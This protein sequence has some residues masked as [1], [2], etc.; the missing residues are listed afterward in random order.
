MTQSMC[1]KAARTPLLAAAIALAF[2]SPFAAAASSKKHFEQVNYDQFIV[3]FKD[4]TVEHANKSQ[5]QQRLDAVGRAQGLHIAQL[6]RMA[7]GADVIHTDHMLTP[8]Q[9]KRLIGSLRADPRVEYAE[10]DRMLYPAFTPD[11]TTYAQQWHYYEAI[12]GINAPTAWDTTSGTGQVIAVLDTGITVHTDL[13]ANIIAGYD[14]ISST[15]TANDGDGRDADAS[16]PG[17][18]V[19]LTQ[20]GTNAADNSSWHGTHVA[21]TIAAVTNNAFGVAG[22][23]YGAKV[24]PVRV[25][26]T[27]GGSTSDISDA[28]AWASGETVAGIP[29]VTTPAD[30]I[31]MS[32]G[33]SGSCAGA[34]QNAV[35]KAVANGTVV[36]VAAGNSNADASGFSPANCNN[37]VTV[38]AVGRTGGRASYSNYGTKIDIAAPGGDDGQ[39]IRS[40][41]NAGTTVPTTETYAGYQGTSMAAPHVAGVA[42]LVGAVNTSLTPAQME[43]LLKVTART[44]PVPCSLGCGSGLLDAGAAVL[45]AGT[46]VLNITDPLDVDEGNSGTKTYT[47]TVNLS[48]A[49]GTAVTFDIATSNGTATAGSDYVAK[50]SLAQ[51]IAA[52][53]TSK[54][55]VVTFN[56]DTTYEDNEVF[57]V[58]ITNVSGPV[59][60]IDDQGV[61]EIGNDDALVL[62]PNVA[63]TGLADGDTGHNKNFTMA[64]PANAT[65]LQFQIS[66][67]T[68]DADLYVRFG[69]APTEATFDCAPY[70][71]GNNETCSQATQAG[72]WYVMVDAYAPYT[73]VTL[74]GSYTIPADTNISVGDVSINEGNGGTKLVT[75][76]VTLSNTS[77]GVVGFDIATADGTATAGS[78]YVA[79]TSTAQTIA[80]GQLS[81][82]FTVTVNGDSAVETNETILANLTNVTG[83]NV[84]DAQGVATITND[85]GPTLSIADAGFK[86][87]DSGTKTLVFTVTLSQASIYAVTYNITTVDGT[88]A[89]GS[90]Y[91]ASTLVAETIPAGQLT[92]TF[93]LTV[94]GDTAV[95]G[96]ETLFVRLSATSVPLTDSQGRGVLVNDDGPTLSINDV[97]ITEGDSGTK[98]LTFTVSLSQLAPAMVTFNAATLNVTAS[99]GPDYDPV[100]LTG[101]TIPYGQLSKNVAVIVRGDTAIEGDETFRLNISGGNVSIVDGIGIGTITDDD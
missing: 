1:R 68:G 89:A 15:T 3:K 24:M 29:N 62:T 79:K 11:D 84:T 59:T 66:G 38:G 17:D 9:Q 2:V 60:V 69:A 93:S 21:G 23:A 73:G 97:A 54:T 37:V 35:N 74:M 61:G 46:P 22:I 6:R 16:D 48:E 94:N 90:D 47:F 80:I 82:T 49:V 50:T 86:E 100:N 5:R 63:V 87:G 12:A 32:L 92:K 44:Q 25:L 64:V 10:V 71:T 4:G 65:N 33:G 83:A 75:F 51:S 34:Q 88:A 36:V 20:C 77:A 45:A 55:F 57:Y 19:T 85:D 67:G 31:N 101:V 39:Y 81:K 58:D 26:G 27:C 70:I 96:N 76:T 30:V 72:T 40:T 7:V 42:A 91:V 28:I 56:G 43:S 98:V 8:D 18:W 99:A 14:F 41:L 78:D 53:L 52:G 13:S 95:E